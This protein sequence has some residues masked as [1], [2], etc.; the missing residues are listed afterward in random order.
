MQELE[1]WKEIIGCPGYFISSFG[2]VKGVRFTHPYKTQLNKKGYLVFRI[3][4][5]RFYSS[6][7]R[8]VAI[9]FVDGDKNLQVNHKDG[10]KT[11]NHYS[12][13]EFISCKDNIKHAIKHGLREARANIAQDMFDT[14]QVKVIKHAINEGYKNPEIAYYF[15]CDHSTISKIRT[16]K[17]YANVAI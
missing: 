4:K 16:G 3:P 13:L 10:V 15:K 6:V 12:N 2:N 5:Y 11:N 9:H 14:T 1:Q 7:H 8:I 17:H